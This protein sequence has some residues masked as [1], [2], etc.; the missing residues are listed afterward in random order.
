MDILENLRA[1]L[2]SDHVLTGKD[3]DA[4][5]RDW[6]G[7]YLGRPLAVLRPADAQQV[8]AILKLAN[9]TATPVV[10]ASG[11]TGLTGGAHAPE[12]LVI[13]VERM[14][15]IR[16]IREEARIAIVGAGV[17]LANLHDAAARH[18]LSFPLTLG[19]KGSAM[20]GGLLSTNAGGSNVLRHGNMRDLCLGLEVVLPTGE[21]MVQMSELHKDN[22]GYNLRHLIIG[23]E[24]TLGVITGAVLKLVPVPR[25][26]ATAMVAVPSLPDALSLLNRLQ[27]ATDGGVEAFEYMAGNYIRHHMKAFPDARPPFEQE[28]EVNLMVEVSAS[29]ARDCDPG[30]DGQVPLVTY[31]EDVLAEMFETGEVLDAVVAQ[32][33]AQRIEM[34]SRREEAGQISLSRLPL[35]NNDVAVPIDRVADFLEMADTRLQ[36]I[37]PGAETIVVAHLGDGN[38]HYVAWPVSQDPT[39]HDAIMEAVEEV[40][41]SLGGSF[42]AE[43][44]IGKSKLR[45]MQRR[46]DPVAIAAMRRIKS[47]LD[48][49]NILNPG[50]V[51]PE[52]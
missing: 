36:S 23:A 43:H 46:K 17:I 34:W 13:S 7:A 50:K 25:A 1:I 47:A 39:V 32:S 52:P 15:Q 14:N 41:L 48:P 29:A 33:E 22:S 4:W 20:I 5:A 49:N 42:S 3:C 45:S 21:I 26:Y 51:L 2:G 31:L 9:E 8:S 35:V 19:A 37:D 44:G 38:I 16:E 40:T 24:G 6:T 27:K 28:H 30:P 11:C 10:P 18:G 12:S